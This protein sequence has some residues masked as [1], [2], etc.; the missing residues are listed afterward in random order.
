MTNKIDT[1]LTAAYLREV[2]RQAERANEQIE[3]LS[4]AVDR[5]TKD[6][7]FYITQCQELDKRLA[8]ATEL[9]TQIAAKQAQVVLGPMAGLEWH[10]ASEVPEGDQRAIIRTREGATF[11][12]EP[13]NGKWPKMVAKW[14][15]IPT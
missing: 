9:N 13:I 2:Q 7:E 10:P 14:M 5:L 3:L 11:M 12:C 8:M 15:Y 1:D 6:K 4:A